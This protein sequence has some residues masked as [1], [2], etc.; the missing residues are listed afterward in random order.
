M[1]EVRVRERRFVLTRVLPAA[2]CCEIR[3]GPVMQFWVTIRWAYTRE[4]DI[5]PIHARALRADWVISGERPY[6]D[7]GGLMSYGP[8]YDDQLRRSA[9]YVDKI[10]KGGKPSGLPIE[11]P[12]KFTLVVNLKTARLLGI[13][14]AES[15]L[16]RADEVI[17]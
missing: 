12:T 5:E 14:I 1:G 11:Q 6:A 13:T 16:L 2:I 8:S 15:I 4:A 9:E 17:Q 3:C 7:E 10:L